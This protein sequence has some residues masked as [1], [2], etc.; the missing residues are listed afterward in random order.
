[1]KWI[2]ALIPG[3]AI[4]LLL[5][6]PARGAAPRFEQTHLRHIGAF[7][8]PGGTFG[9]STFGYSESLIAFNPQHHSLFFVGHSHQQHIAEID[10][11]TPSTSQHLNDLPI[12]NVRQP[13][14]SIIN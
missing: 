14:T 9:A 5:G 7:R 13:F 2:V 1:M 10:I 12:A 11:P 3:L 4:T 6:A 8:V